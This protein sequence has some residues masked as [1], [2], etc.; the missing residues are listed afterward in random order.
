[1][2]AQFAQNRNTH[3]TEKPNHALFVFLAKLFPTKNASEGV[4]GRDITVGPSLCWYSSVLSH[5]PFLLLFF[6]KL[7]MASFHHTGKR[8]EWNQSLE[9]LTFTNLTLLGF[10][11][12]ENEARHQTPFCPS[13]FDTSNGKGMEVIM[14]FLLHRLDP[15]RARESFRGVWPVND[16]TKSREFRNILFDWLKKLEEEEAIPKSARKSLLQTATGHRFVELLFYVSNHVLRS[17][18][19][20]DLS[21]YKM[22]QIPFSL[23]GLSSPVCI[24]LIRATKLH[25]IRETRKFVT[26]GARMAEVRSQWSDF[27]DLLDSRCSKTHAAAFLFEEKKV[28]T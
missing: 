16:K 2:V 19:Q 7:A 24:A 1:M 17:I 10:D 25:I 13:M 22:P 4:I 14:F 21:S 6:Q 12:R 3:K 5:V 11:V 15:G 23:S 26:N 18:F 27:D 9:E 8:I 20:R 28:A